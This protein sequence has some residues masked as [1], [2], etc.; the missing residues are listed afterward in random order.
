MTAH[1]FMQAVKLTATGMLGAYRLQGTGQGLC[2][3]ASDSQ[4]TGFDVLRVAYTLGVISK[5]L[6]VFTLGVASNSH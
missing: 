2:S 3:V 1:R 5:P 4:K 6:A